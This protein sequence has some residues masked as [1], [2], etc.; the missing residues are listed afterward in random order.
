MFELFRDFLFSTEIEISFKA[1]EILVKLS[2]HCL[3][4][5]FEISIDVK[6]IL[7][8]MVRNRF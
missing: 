1:S 7:N 5:E 2:V 6:T 4:S 8:E 3:E